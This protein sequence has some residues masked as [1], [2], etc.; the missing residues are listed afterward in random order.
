VERKEREKEVG[1]E[2]RKDGRREME[3]GRKER[4]RQ[5]DHVMN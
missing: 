3:A 2:G 1:R 5:L 4:E